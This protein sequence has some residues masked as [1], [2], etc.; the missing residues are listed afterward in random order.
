MVCVHVGGLGMAW[1]ILWMLLTVDEPARDSGVSDGEK[2]YIN[3]AMTTQTQQPFHAQQVT[4]SM[5]GFLC[6][7]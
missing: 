4:W 6:I 7:Q 2:D 5:A 3:E 1:F